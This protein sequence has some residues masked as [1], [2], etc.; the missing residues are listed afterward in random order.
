M[1]RRGLGA[2]A[3]ALALGLGGAGLLT[4]QTPGGGTPPVALLFCGTASAQSLLTGNY[5]CLNED[6]TQDSAVATTLTATGSP[7]IN[8]TPTRV[9]LNGSSQYY[10]TPAVA[11][12][13]GDQSACVVSYY[14]DVLAR[15]ILISKDSNSGGRS[16]EFALHDNTLGQT[17]ILY[18]ISGGA[19]LQGSSVTQD[20]WHL[21]CYTYDFISSGA[22][23]IR[24]YLDGAEVLSLVGSAPD[25][26]AQA[27]V[28]YHIGH[29]PYTGAEDF[30]AGDFRGAFFTGKVLSAGEISA[31]YSS[32]LPVP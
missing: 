25:I 24:V 11:G 6:G 19:T 20:A 4:S 32:V 18:G 30:F 3:L 15:Q 7:T 14:P 21:V 9:T 10:A 31:L 23:T 22:N 27:S 12:P 13:T 26:S 17:R 16:F 29:R 2:L 1:N 8:A 5:F 28:P